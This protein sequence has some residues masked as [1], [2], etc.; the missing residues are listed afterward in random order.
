MSSYKYKQ[1][2]KYVIWEKCKPLPYSR[3]PTNKCKSNDRIRKSSFV[4]HY[5]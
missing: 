4:K 5:N 3:M 1:T 2:N